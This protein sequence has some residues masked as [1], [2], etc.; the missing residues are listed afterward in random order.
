MRKLISIY[1]IIILSLLVANGKTKNGCHCI[2]IE[3]ELDSI[4]TV[5]NN[6]TDTS[7][8][9]SL[10][11]SIAQL[12]IL[13]ALDLL[14]NNSY[15][16]RVNYNKYGILSDSIMSVCYYNRTY[17]WSYINPLNYKKIL[18]WINFYRTLIDKNKYNCIIIDAIQTTLELNNLFRGN[19]PLCSSL[20]FGDLHFCDSLKSNI[21]K[22]IFSSNK[23][24]NWLYLQ[25]NDSIM[26][27]IIEQFQDNI[28]IKTKIY[29]DSLEAK[30]RSYGGIWRHQP[31]RP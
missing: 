28:Y 30:Y 10:S 19:N 24:K 31:A 23:R 6:Y 20:I 1:I 26:L 4:A 16:V 9:R 2:D 11:L 14:I 13:H 27:K 3:T 25:K 18:D 17:L 22:E 15:P 5:L 8:N 12:D 21:D 29:L 7:E